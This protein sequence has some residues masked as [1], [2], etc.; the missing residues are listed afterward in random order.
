[1]REEVIMTS[2]QPLTFSI[3][4]EPSTSID[5]RFRWEIHRGADAAVL[6]PNSYVNE[7]EAIRAAADAMA[8]MNIERTL[9]ADSATAPPFLLPST[10]LG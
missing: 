2:S 1:M 8:R 4:V 5:G 9:D 7:G 10:H 3:V 6:S